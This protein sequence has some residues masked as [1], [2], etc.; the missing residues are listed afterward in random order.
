MVS[1]ASHAPIP[2]RLPLLAYEATW[3]CTSSISNCKHMFAACPDCCRSTIGCS[4]PQKRKGKKLSEMSQVI[5]AT[6]KVSVSCNKSYLPHH[7][8]KE[9]KG[10]VPSHPCVVKHFP[11]GHTQVCLNGQRLLSSHHK[12][13]NSRGAQGN[14]SSI[15]DNKTALQS[16]HQYFLKGGAESR[17]TSIHGRCPCPPHPC[18][19]YKTFHPLLLQY[20]P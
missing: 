12:W 11:A 4:K 8:G 17:N 9:R 7:S 2:A 5:T 15:T 1:M 3:S 14:V 20:A 19:L 16:L 6:Q 10:A 18:H 13:F